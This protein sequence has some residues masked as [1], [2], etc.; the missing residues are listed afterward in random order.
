MAASA[1]AGA[2]AYPAPSGHAEGG[3]PP[4]V[5]WESDWPGDEQTRESCVK[6]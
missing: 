5:D 1:L 2:V 4:D 6:A 3:T